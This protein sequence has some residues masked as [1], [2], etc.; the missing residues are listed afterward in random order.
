M[1][2]LL[3]DS[4]PS[5]ELPASHPDSPL[6]PILYAVSAD[7]G[8]RWRGALYSLNPLNPDAARHF[9]SSAREIIARIL[10]TKAPDSVVEAS[11]PG[12]ELTQQ[13]TPSRRAKIRYFLRKNGMNQEELENLIET[14]MNNVVDRFH[15]FNKGTHGSAGA[16]NRSQLQAIRMRTE[17]GIMFLCGL[18]N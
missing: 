1:N 3:D 4:N 9:C 18:I 17:D 14:D 6:T 11:M 16:F 5:N 15:I 8:D 2:S 13:G 10:D 12:R 7:L